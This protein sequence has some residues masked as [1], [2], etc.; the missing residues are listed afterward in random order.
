MKKYAIGIDIGGTNV[1]A[2]IIDESG[3]IIHVINKKTMAEGGP[4]AVIKE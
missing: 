3:S 4:D 1:P 2:A